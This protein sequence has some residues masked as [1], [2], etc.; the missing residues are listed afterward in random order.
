LENKQKQLSAAWSYPI[1][2]TPL[3][4]QTTNIPKAV[5]VN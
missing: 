1:S 5:D 2:G 4:S 3:D